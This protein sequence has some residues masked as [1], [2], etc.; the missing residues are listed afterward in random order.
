MERLKPLIALLNLDLLLFIAV[1]AVKA[2]FFLGAIMGFTAFLTWVE[3][4]LSSL[5][6]DR[7]GPN[8]AAIFGFTLLGLFHPIADGIKLMMKEDFVPARADKVL[9]TLAPI[10]TLVPVLAAFAVI[11]FG[12][13]VDIMGYRVDLVIAKL[14][15]GL[16]YVLAVS[17]F[18]IYGTFLAGWASKS[19]FALLGALRG[20]AQMISYEVVLGLTLV[21]LLMI[22]GTADL[23]QIVRAQGR[24]LFGFIPAWGIVYQFPAFLLF[25][26]A[27]MAENK[28]T[29]FDVV[30][31]DSEIIGYFMEYSSMRFAVFMFAEFIEI[32]LVAMLAATLFLGGWQIPYL[33][34]AGFLFPG[35]RSIAVYPYAVALA[36]MAAFALKTAFMCW[37]LMTLR[38][39]VPRFRFDQVMKLAWQGVLPLSLLNILVTGLA[40]VLA[41]KL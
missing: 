8:R 15:L 24:L 17:G 3:R 6:Q 30:E 27:A 40:L 5:M 23:Q 20:A 18:A 7:I 41:G 36:Q 19:N 10:I 37:V 9:F 35:G 39:T 38:W 12:N 22:Y 14:P 1:S 33:S 28:R 26:T 29:P 21:G 34:E 11:P 4:K 32:I 13:Y 16:L 2:G 31:G 25:L